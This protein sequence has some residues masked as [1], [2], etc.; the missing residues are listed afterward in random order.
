[1]ETRR[2]GRAGPSVPVIC[3]GTWGLG[4]GFG[5]IPE[6]QATA[7]IETAIDEGLTFI[8][9]AEGY[10]EGETLLGKAIRGKREK[11]FLAT[12]V[13]GL[14]HSPEHIDRA[15]ASSLRTLGTDYIDLYQV[16]QPSEEHPIEQTMQHLVR[17]RDA[18]KLRYIGVSNFTAEET[19]EALEYGPV[20]SSQPRYSMLFREAEES[21]LPY[22]LESG[23]GVISFS[24]LTKGMLGGRY[25]PGHEFP[26]D[27]ERHRWPEFHGELFEGIFAVTEQLKGWAEDQGRDIVQLAI[28]WVLANPSVTAAIV[29]LRTPE[30]ARHNARAGGWV[31]TA[32]DLEEIDVIQ[33]DLRLHYTRP[34]R[35]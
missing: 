23:V 20:H 29:G 2:L 31:L 25:R 30:Q 6:S 15:L 26:P 27:D 14:D 28:A 21:I 7:A 35:T 9:T 5:K 17:L 33:G 32:D 22:C 13:S 10:L 19:A 11:L 18:G 1:M 34:M 4:G 24:A 16:H 12:K 8:D 3:F